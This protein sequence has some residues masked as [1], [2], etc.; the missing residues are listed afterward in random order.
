MTHCISVFEVLL[1]CLEVIYCSAIP[2][3]LK[4]STRYIVWSEDGRQI[5]VS[6]IYG[7]F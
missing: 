1:W 2:S 6:V 5:A 7:S 3:L 4:C